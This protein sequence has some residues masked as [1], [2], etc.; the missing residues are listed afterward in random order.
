MLTSGCSQYID[1]QDDRT[2]CGAELLRGRQRC[3]SRLPGEGGEIAIRGPRRSSVQKAKRR[4][5]IE[6]DVDVKKAG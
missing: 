3:T 2:R 1:A 6:A 4:W 5:L